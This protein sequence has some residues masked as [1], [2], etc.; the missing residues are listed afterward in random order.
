MTYL[1]RGTSKMKLYGGMVEEELVKHG[2]QVLTIP[3]FFIQNPI[4]G[5]LIPTQ[6]ENLI[7]WNGHE[8]KGELTVLNEHLKRE[9]C[10][11]MFG[12]CTA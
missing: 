10:P 9:N 12:E 8:V 5:S 2:G 7:R 1:A 11:M 4:S 6:L 3:F